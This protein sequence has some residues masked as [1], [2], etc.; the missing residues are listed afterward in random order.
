V[1]YFKSAF[2]KERNSDM[3][4][5]NYKKLDKTTF[6]G[7]VDNALEI[8][9]SK[10]NIKNEFK[11]TRI[12]LFNLKAMDN[13]T[14]PNEMYIFIFNTNILDEKNKNLDEESYN[15]QVLGEHGAIQ[16]LIE[17]SSVGEFFELRYNATSVLSNYL[18]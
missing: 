13:K 16:K 1:N 9:L 8:S 18:R 14:M 11:I 3:I 4:R 5:F 15:Y 10:Y 7:W 17:I 6:V 2:E 12:W